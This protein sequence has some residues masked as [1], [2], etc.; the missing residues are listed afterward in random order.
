MKARD[1]FQRFGWRSQGRLRRHPLIAGI[2]VLALVVQFGCATNGVDKRSASFLHFPVPRVAFYELG[3]AA[4]VS[5]RFAPTFAIVDLQLKDRPHMKDTPHRVAV[6]KEGSVGR[7][8]K[9]G[10]EGFFAPLQLGAAGANFLERPGA[11]TILLAPYLGKKAGERIQTKASR[12]GDRVR[13]EHA[14]EDPALKVKARFVDALA[15]KPGLTNLHPISEPAIR[16]EP[17]QLAES[18]GAVGALDFITTFW[19]LSRE[20]SLNLFA[21]IGFMSHMLLRRGFC[22]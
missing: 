7:A 16:Y 8:L 22:G 17:Y 19:G 2:L 11:H 15:T 10:L 9:G 13:R 20:P 4:I 12:E 5:G 21:Q 1:T 14:I 6:R 18:L 3:K